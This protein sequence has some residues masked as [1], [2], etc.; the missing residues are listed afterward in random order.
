MGGWFYS[1]LL[2]GEIAVEVREVH[3]SQ[4]PRGLEGKKIAFLSDVHAGWMFPAKRVAQTVQAL[5]AL[6]PD[7]LLIGGDLAETRQ[8][9]LEVI[10]ALGTVPAPLGRYAVLGNNDSQRFM[11]AGQRQL[12]QAMERSGISLL[13]NERAEIAV[14][15]GKLAVVGLDE[16]KYGRPRTEGLFAG[17]GG[18]NFCVLLSHYPQMAVAVVQ[19]GSK[20]GPQLALCG[21][22]HGGQFRLGRLT[23]Y[24]V[25]YERKMRTGGPAL[26]HGWRRIGRTWILVSNGLG[27]SSLPLR[28]GAQPQIHK[29]ILRI[30]KNHG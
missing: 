25:G 16:M 23:P 18:E 27:T 14:E 11:G 5:S 30:E 20:P 28:I 26:V 6:E 29:I 10:R 13:V 4:L 17:M 3:V 9:E 2:G 15:G 8:D 19:S 21:H 24:A 7:L 1:G 12:R 22:T